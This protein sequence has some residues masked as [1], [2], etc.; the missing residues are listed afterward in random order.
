MLFFDSRCHFEQQSRG[1][2]QDFPLGEGVQVIVFIG[3]CSLLV[4]RLGRTS[5]C[6]IEVE[7]KGGGG[8]DAPLAT[9]LSLLSVS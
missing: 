8:L 9:P 7:Q 5:E 1:Q 4:D 3:K 2:S 6:Y